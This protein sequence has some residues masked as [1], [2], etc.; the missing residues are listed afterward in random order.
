M[1]KQTTL[2][3][4]PEPK[5]YGPRKFYECTGSVLNR[6]HTYNSPIKDYA[7]RCTCDDEYETAEI[8]SERRFY[9]G[10]VEADVSNN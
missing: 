10:T 3:H 1:I 7:L 5:L 2:Y 6:G 9:T 8:F 4:D